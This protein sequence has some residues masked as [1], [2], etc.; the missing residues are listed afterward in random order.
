MKYIFIKDNEKIFPIEKMCQILQ[1]D[2]GSYY[3]WK[4]VKATINKNR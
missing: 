1:A 2:R 4:K 3:L